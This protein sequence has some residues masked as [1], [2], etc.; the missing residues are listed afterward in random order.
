LF[1]C[2]VSHKLLALR[3][4]LKDLPPA[5]KHQR[6]KGKEKA[7]YEVSKAMSIQFCTRLN[8]LNI[9]RPMLKNKKAHS[10]PAYPSPHIIDS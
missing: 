7:P 2:K 5:L 1:P 10:W 3:A 9:P 6:R 8:C 4:A